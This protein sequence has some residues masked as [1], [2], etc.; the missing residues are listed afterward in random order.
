MTARNRSDKMF[1]VPT[2]YRPTTTLLH[3]IVNVRVA[4]NNPACN[5]Q[6][7][8][9]EVSSAQC[10]SA[11]KEDTSGWGVLGQRTRGYGFSLR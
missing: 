3:S 7:S 11:G 1:L 6:A 10:A 4:A 5:N 9:I 2:L 8:A